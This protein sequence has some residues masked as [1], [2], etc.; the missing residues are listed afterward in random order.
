M[1]LPAAVI[2]LATLSYAEIAALVAAGLSSITQFSAWRTDYT[3]RTANAA[4]TQASNLQ[5]DA[6]KAAAAAEEVR[7]QAFERF[8]KQFGQNGATI[9]P[10]EVRVPHRSFNSSAAYTQAFTTAAI[11]TLAAKVHQIEADL[12]E[13][14]QSLDKIANHL[15]TISLAQVQGWSNDKDGFGGYVYNLIKGEIHA[16]SKEGH[17]FYVYHPDTVWHSGFE[18]RLGQEPLPASFGGYSN[19]LEAIFLL[20]WANRQTRIREDQHAGHKAVFYLLLPAYDVYAINDRLIVDPSVGPLVIKG[21]TYQS[22]CLAHFRFFY[23]PNNCILQDVGNLHDEDSVKRRNE[24]ELLAQR[25]FIGGQ[26]GS[27]GGVLASVLCPL[28]APVAIP[29]AITS[30]MVSMS[31]WG[32]LCL[33]EMLEDVPSIRHLGPPPLVNTSTQETREET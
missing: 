33:R 5:A 8:R 4:A 1:V 30:H 12:R 18:N 26:A 6:A 28:V 7:K 10:R 19:D 24:Q 22:H 2:S 32:S 25:G 17:Y 29:V 15:R 11:V 31:C 3:T 23:I 27:L 20:M 9:R 16:K 14:G 21:Y 13:I